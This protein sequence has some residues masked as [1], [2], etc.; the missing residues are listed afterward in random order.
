MHSADLESPPL[1][2]DLTSLWRGILAAW[3]SGLRKDAI[4]S[5][6]TLVT[7]LN[8]GEPAQASRF[9]RWLCERLFD[10][11]VGWK[12]QWGGNAGYED[13]PD[14]ALSIFPLT[15][16]VVIPHLARELQQPTGQTLRWLYQAIVGLSGRLPPESR[17]QLDGLL[18][19]ACGKDAGLLDLLRLAAPTDERARRWAC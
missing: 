2:D 13:A 10:D 15:T 9:G 8:Q 6:E 17:D 4:R 3:N 16:G 12:G 5:A 1:P 7:R 14:Y 19:A 18:A 11:S